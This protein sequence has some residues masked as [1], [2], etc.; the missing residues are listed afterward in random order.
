MTASATTT[1][2]CPEQTA[3]DDPEIVPMPNH[4]DLVKWPTMC[5]KIHVPI[6][7]DGRLVDGIETNAICTKCLKTVCVA[8]LEAGALEMTIRNRW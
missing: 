3:Y 7:C 6:S 8:C 5:G 4:F 1:R 2:T